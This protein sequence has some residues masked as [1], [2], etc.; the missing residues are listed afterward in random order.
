[1]IL[2][3]IKNIPNLKEKC[4]IDHLYC[5][6]FIKCCVCYIFARLFCM[7]K[8]EDLWNKEKSFSTHFK[9]SLHYWHNQILT[10]W[11]FRCHEIIKC[12]SMKLEKHI[13]LNNLGSEQ[14]GNKI[15]PEYYKINFIKKIYEK[16]GLETS[17]RSFLIS[18][19]PLQKGFWGGLH[20][21]LNKLW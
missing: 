7:S 4:V 11:I 15:W 10:F 8:R 1:M 12:L 13:L 6:R 2:S 9:S 21:D 3:F 18:R 20:A 5:I 19:N 16:C 17:S 14:S